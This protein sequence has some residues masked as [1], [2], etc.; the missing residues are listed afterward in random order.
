MPRP[1]S[2]PVGAE[3]ARIVVALCFLAGPGPLAGQALSDT[4]SRPGIEGDVL[5]ASTFRP[6]RGARVTLH[7]GPS[8]DSMPDSGAG[9]AVSTMV[10]GDEGRY[11]F[12]A[13]P[14]G[15]YRLGVHR[16]GYRPVIID[17]DL[18]DSRDARVS[19]GMRVV[20]VWLKALESH[21]DVA[22]SYG[23]LESQSMDR[24]DARIRA[25]RRR[26]RRFLSSS[27]RELTHADVVEAVTLGET[28]LF[29]GFQRLPGVSTRDEYSAE[30]WI[31]GS[32]WDHTRVYFDGL[33]LFNA[34]HAGGALSGVGVD[35]VGSAH[36]HAGA[37]P[38]SMG[39]GA[40]AV[41]DVRSRSGGGSGE[42]RGAG[43]LS[44][45]SARLA[46]DQQSADGKTAWMVA[47][48]RS[49]L[50]WITSAVGSATGDGSIHLPY[51]FDGITA[52]VDRQLDATRTLEASAILE[53]DHVSGD[54]PDIRHGNR[55]VSG[56]AG[57]RMSLVAP[58]GGFAARHT[59]GISRF[60]T[61]VR[62]V[63]EDSLIGSQFSSETDGP[64]A[65]T[66]LHASAG[67]AFELDASDA[68][69]WSFGYEGVI[70]R[71]EFDGAASYVIA[72]H[73]GDDTYVRR[74]ST[75]YV[76]A[77]AERRFL[78]TPS[79]TA[80]FGLRVDAG[81]RVAGAGVARAAPRSAL[82]LSLDSN[83]TLTA[84][85]GR[86]YL[87]A[88]TTW[89]TDRLLY[90]Q[91]LPVRLWLVADA[92][93]PAVRTDAV[94]VGGERWF[95]ERTLLTVNAYARHVAGIIM[96]DP[97]PGPL[98]DRPLFVTASERAEGIEAGVRRLG[99][100]VSASA[101]YTVSRGLLRSGPFIFQSPTTRRHSVN[102]TASWQLTRVFQISG[103]F[104]AASGVPFTRIQEGQDSTAADGT[105]V[106][107]EP[108]IAGSPGALRTGAFRALD[109]LADWRFAFYGTELTAFVQLRNALGRSQSAT[110]YLGYDECATTRMSPAGVAECIGKD[111]FAP[112]LP[113]I[114]VIGLRLQF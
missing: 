79:L 22:A 18:R 28:D 110:L 89:R 36:L 91:L 35:A 107:S 106:W 14:P 99:E 114:P 94:T 109:L 70:N 8:D 19:V 5:D 75:K 50:D 83:T 23:R 81:N 34:V 38:A 20:P 21:A 65:S 74:G 72:G 80:E 44:V 103:A 30:L 62:V 104:T 9:R 10:T 6:I 58:I 47:A 49:Y 55:W 25:A 64:M 53:R 1:D 78:V 24:G 46:L 77:W 85:A 63:P 100:R 97:T 82:R 45:L 3:L 39:E 112:G 17:V 48:R 31:R 15:Q 43:E 61:R 32:R 73:L 41:L 27:V 67:S 108:P 76:S 52:R 29:R 102:A 96:P 113:R 93:T 4:V 12:G 16:I 59:L 98:L 42:I 69:A 87:Y 54:L 7:A 92:T 68:G 95:G 37:R 90:S 71:A 11:R 66:V 84:S 33:P 56:N 88:Q 26:Q 2:R 57:A 40:A 86:S 60:G 51:H 105:L 13:L 111:E 101:T